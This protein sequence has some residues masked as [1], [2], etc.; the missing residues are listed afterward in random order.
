MTYDAPELHELGIA[1][2]LIQGVLGR[3]S[4]VGDLFPP[5]TYL[6]DFDE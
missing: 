4:D 2:E 5:S 1:D 6:E 3:G